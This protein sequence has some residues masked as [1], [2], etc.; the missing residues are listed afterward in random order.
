MASKLSLYPI[1]AV[2]NDWDEFPLDTRVLPFKLLSDLVV[3]DVSNLFNENTFKWVER[4][5]GK[6]DL[7]DL[8]SFRYAIVHRYT[9]TQPQGGPDDVDSEKLVREVAACL[10]LIRPMRQRALFMQGELNDETGFNPQHF[11]H[12]IHLMEVPEVQKLWHLRNADLELLRELTQAFVTVMNGDEWKIRMAVQFHEGGHWQHLYWK[13]RFSLWMAGIEAL[14]TTRDSD[15]NG[16]LVTVERVKHLLGATTNIYEPG[17]LQSFLPQANIYIGDVLD[18]MYKLR[19]YV[20]H[21]ERVPDR[22]NEV[23]RAGVNGHVNLLSVLI[24]ATSFVL[25]KSVIKILKNNLVQ[26]FKDSHAS[27]NYWCT[28]GLTKTN[29]RGRIAVEQVLQR[30]GRALSPAE[31]GHILNR[32]RAEQLRLCKEA[33]IMSYLEYGLRKGTLVATK[34]GEYSHISA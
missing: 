2:G 27:Q 32:K 25:R 22:Y 5:M 16:R 12:P 9:T 20:V 1:Y 3:E 13:P 23:R 28:F 11:D 18:E 15:H 19:N 33:D 31:I 24:E 30:A 7:E 4:E 8:R 21:G 34:S 14:Y 29:I 17:D 6:Y 10:R 26:E